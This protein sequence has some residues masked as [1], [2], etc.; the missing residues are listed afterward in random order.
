[1]S[2]GRRVYLEKPLFNL[3]LVDVLSAVLSVR[4][5]NALLYMVLSS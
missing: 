5:T 3:A 4:F 1:M 2:D